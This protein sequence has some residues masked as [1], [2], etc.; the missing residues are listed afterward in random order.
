MA[1]I[2][3]LI[4]VNHGGNPL[5]LNN[6]YIASEVSMFK[7]IGYIPIC[8]KCLFEMANSYY[9]KYKDMKLSIYYMC[10]KIDIAFNSNI[11]EGAFGEGAESPQKSFFSH[12]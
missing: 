7:G 8:K 1:E 3:K 10:R 11:F 9:D 2:K 12:I 6:F 5:G 4:C